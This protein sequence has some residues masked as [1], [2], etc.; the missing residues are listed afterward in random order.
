MRHEFK[1]EISHEDYLIISS[2]LKHLISTDKNVGQEGT[3]RVRSLYFDNFQ[4]K[5][6]REKID[7]VDRREKFRIRYYNEDTAFV[8]LEKKSKINGLCDKRSALLTKEQTIQICHG[9]IDFLKKTDNKLLQEFYAKLK[10]QML[11]PQT[12]VDYKRAPYVYAPGNVRI[13][14]DSDIRTSLY[15]N[16]LFEADL[17]TIPTLPTLIM[18]VKYDAFLPEIIRMAVGVPCRRAQSFSKY[19]VSRMYG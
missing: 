15:Q 9:E 7:G 13:T 2:R 1:H 4:D 16:K 6:L 14:F 17:I 18:E 8:R 10:Y 19:A 11:R 12:I 3:Y 5:A